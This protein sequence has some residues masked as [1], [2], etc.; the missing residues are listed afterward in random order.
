MS[1]FA[2]TNRFEEELDNL[3]VFTDPNV[4]KLIWF[5]RMPRNIRDI[6]NRFGSTKARWG[7]YCLKLEKLGILRS[8]PASERLGKANWTKRQPMKCYISD[9]YSYNLYFDG[10]NINLIVNNEPR[11][12]R[13]VG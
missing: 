10:E 8:V 7:T 4:W 13:K 2:P 3:L 9:I 1:G 12:V 11:F 5:C 6:I